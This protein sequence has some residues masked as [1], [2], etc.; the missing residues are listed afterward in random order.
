MIATGIMSNNEFYVA[1]VYNEG[2]RRG[3]RYGV[4]MIQKMWGLGV[5]ADLVAFLRE[6][7]R[8]QVAPMSSPVT[9]PVRIIAHRANLHGPDHGGENMPESI[10]TALAAGFDVSCDVVCLLRKFFPWDS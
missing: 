1:P 3:Q 6:K 7:K 8:I 4:D 10:S 5:P 9:H 2:I